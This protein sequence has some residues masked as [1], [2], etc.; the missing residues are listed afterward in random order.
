MTFIFE[1][2]GGEKGGIAFIHYLMKA[3]PTAEYSAVISFM[4]CLSGL[5]QDPLPFLAV[6][7]CC[8]PRSHVE[9]GL[10]PRPRLS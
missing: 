10:S 2:E 8:Y 5:E 9:S 3:I 6:L 4:C 7:V 1:N